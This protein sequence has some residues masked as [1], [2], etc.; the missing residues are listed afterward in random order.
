VLWLDNAQ[1]YLLTARSELGEQV[2]AE[3]RSLLRNPSRGPVLVLG[4]IWQEYW[5]I[6]TTAPNPRAVDSHA[7]ARA[8]LTGTQM[9]VPAVFSG[10]DLDALRAKAARDPRLAQAAAKAEQGQITQFLAGAPALLERYATASDA[11]RALIEAAMDGR[12]LGHGPALP[13][14]LLQAAAPGYLTDAQWDLLGE[15][16][17]EKALA[18]NAAPCRGV[19]GPLTRI[20]PRPGHLAPPQPSYQLADYLDQTGR[21][22]RAAMSIPAA[23]WEALANNGA[24]D[25]LVRLA[26]E[27]EKRHLYRFAFKLR[28]AAANNGDTES[29][30]EAAYM[31]AAAGRVE[32]ALVWYQ[33][34]ASNGNTEALFEA[35]YLLADAGRVEEALAW[36][37]RAANAGSDTDRHFALIEAARMLAE[38]GW[39][40]ES[41]AWYERAASTDSDTLV[42]YFRELTGRFM[43]GGRPPRGRR[44]TVMYRPFGNTGSQLALMDAARKL[45]EAGHIDAALAW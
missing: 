18:Y 41:L 26:I 23:L 45:A 4:T 21:T 9:R 28:A 35:A 39:L 30:L 29:F 1:H 16:W 32:E 25:D 7:Q 34:G 14:A 13:L 42:W 27:A 2:A 12:R 22:T 6:L 37:E 17:L 36:Y 33:H 8:L 43:L 15:D 11:A 44:G 20:R 40:E 3:L 31:L 10:K 5:D 38:A 24:K 19:R